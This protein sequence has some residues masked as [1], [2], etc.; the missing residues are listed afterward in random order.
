MSTYLL[1]FKQ[2]LQRFYDIYDTVEKHYTDGKPPAALGPNHSCACILKHE[3]FCKMSYDNIQKIMQTHHIIV[4]DAPD[5]KMEFDEAAFHSLN[6][7]ESLNRI[8][9]VHGE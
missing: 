2:D 5:P 6:P 7:G 8:I 4:M 3:D 9:T 1:Q